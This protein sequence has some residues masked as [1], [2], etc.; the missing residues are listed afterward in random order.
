M[1]RQTKGSSLNCQAGNLTR[2]ATSHY[3]GSVKR[4]LLRL[5]L[6]ALTA[7]PGVSCESDND[8]LNPPPKRNHLKL[9]N[10]NAPAEQS[11]DFKKVVVHKKQNSRIHADSSNETQDTIVM[12]LLDL[13][14]K[15]KIHSHHFKPGFRVMKTNK[16]S[17][18]NP[19]AYGQHRSLDRRVIWHQG[20][21]SK[22]HS[23]AALTLPVPTSVTWDI[24]VP[25]N[26][27]F[28]MDYAV[29]KYVEGHREAHLTLWVNNVNKIWSTLEAGTAIHRLKRWRPVDLDLA[30]W[31]G[32]TIQLT[33]TTQGNAAKPNQRITALFADP[34]IISRTQETLDNVLLV[35]VDA[36]RAD[37][38]GEA[39]KKRGLP[40]LFPTMESLTENGVSM[41]QA[42]SL[43]NQT[44]PST[45]GLLASQYP[46]IGH[47]H[48]IRWNYTVAMK[49]AFYA[50]HPPLLPQLMRS[51]GYRNI[52]IG[53]NLFLFDNTPIGLDAGFDE[54]ID[55]RNP[56]ENT[57]WITDSA[58][59]WLQNH[60]DERWFMV[61]NY[62]AP[63]RPYKPPKESFDAFKPA[64]EN[65]QGFS[66]EYLG[67][68]KWTDQHLTKIMATLDELKLR[69]R[70]LIILTA[71]HGEIMDSRHECW[72]KNWKSSCLHHHGKTL[73]DEEINVPLVFYWPGK[74][75][76]RTI[77]HPMSHLDL[78]PTLLGLLQMTP[79]AGQM[80]RDLS[81]LIQTNKST[82]EVP[83]IAEARLST[84]LR[85]QGYKY[86]V[87]DR[88]EHIKF[89]QKTLFDPRRSLEELYDLNKDPQELNNLVLSA[90]SESKQLSKMRNAL[91]QV[92][93]ELAR[94]F[95][96]IQASNSVS[97][98]P[99]PTELIADVG[100][101]W[102]NFRFHKGQSQGRFE[103]VISCDG[104]I[105]EWDTNSPGIR[106]EGKKELRITLDGKLEDVS[107][108]LRTK[109]DDANLQVNVQLDGKTLG[110]H[111][112]YVGAYGLKLLDSPLLITHKA[113]HRLGLAPKHGPATIAG[114]D[115]GLFYWRDTGGNTPESEDLES[116]GQI[117]SEVREL[118]KSWG[119]V[120]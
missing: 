7:V 50:A 5:G 103:G 76:A 67:E 46:T 36:Q 64:L 8:G 117:D 23:R 18:P 95:N 25:S 22:W 105:S 63:H 99:V 88:R 52:H 77:D 110:A 81:A 9:N 104:E 15:A 45:Y 106:L 54:I 13:L 38:L 120:N 12:H 65:I 16:Q 119:Y 21:T 69:Q 48:H 73:F 37:T 98:P 116:A 114:V 78:A 11:S 118:M 31:A 102:S 28:Q 112:F 107:I 53:D 2:H 93:A 111:R 61:L 39:R 90:K 79:V 47:F 3:F 57:A 85:W 32:K 26:G 6:I 70:T 74:L 66:K 72:A 42:F 62:T 4:L 84:G 55:H 44:R 96:H 43:G 113:H 20:K 80:G 19:W 59:S 109:P 83:I 33:L 100:E 51:I 60:K 14:P 115:A 71:D 30:Q 101:I 86:I 40:R 91:G 24:K 49:N 29:G 41:T 68:I 87:H 56:L 75:E 89:S 94:R 10:K 34:V 82:K 1:T 17:I 58:R 108:R 92:R 27:R 97:A 35:I